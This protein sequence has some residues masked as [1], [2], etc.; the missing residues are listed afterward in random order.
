MPQD[1]SK[2]R[3][4]EWL[5]TRVL[6]RMDAVVLVNRSMLRHPNI[7]NVDRR[8]VH[9][10]NNGIAEQPP[11]DESRMERA[12]VRFCDYPLV[13][14][15][16]GRLS[17]EKGFCILVDAFSR[18]VRGGLPARLVLIGDGRRRSDLVAQVNRLG[19]QEHVLMTGFLDNAGAYLPLFKVLVIPSLTE[20]LPITLLEAMRAGTPVVASR[21]G[22]IPQVITDNR[23]GLLVDPGDVLT[24]GQRIQRL[25]T[26]DAL[27]QKI[28][29]NARS[30]FRQNYTSEEMATCY[31]SLYI[32]V[33][34][35]FPIGGR[36]RVARD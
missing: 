18:I 24:L 36:F 1:L 30:L 23:S 29:T 19:I 15:A 14:G 13:I 16:I 33:A 5:D 11:R 28:A 20:G 35:A 26:E 3:L 34:R 17:D 9:I 8:N 2:M 7:R 12:V 22:G 10:I 4:Y 25:L 6:R 27:R 32:R 21:V 31:L